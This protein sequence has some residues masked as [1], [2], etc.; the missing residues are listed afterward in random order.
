MILPSL[1]KL[2]YLQ[3]VELGTNKLIMP[4]PEELFAT[5]NL[6]HLDLSNN[7]LIGDFH[8]EIRNCHRLQIL[9]LSNNKITG[10]LPL[11][12]VSNLTQLERLDLCAN[13]SV[14]FMVVSWSETWLT[15]L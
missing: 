2:A 10:A 3:V 9:V 8:A 11:G 5:L 13:R 15:S 4:I 1:G 6:T 7:N 12:L 14:Y